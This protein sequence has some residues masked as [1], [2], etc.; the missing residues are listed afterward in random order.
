MSEQKSP[1]EYVDEVE[2]MAREYDKIG[3]ELV[4]I[5]VKKA[6]E[7]LI[8]RARE[9][10]KSDAQAERFW[11][12]TPEGILELQYSFKLKSIEKL[13]SAIKLKLRLLSE[14]SKNYY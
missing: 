8:I 10:V 4:K 7:I 2:A 13:M 6:T 14:E 3:N 5:K 12:S 9:G 11:Q 1:R